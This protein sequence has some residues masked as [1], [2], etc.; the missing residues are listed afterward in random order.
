MVEQ[1]NKMF[2]VQDPFDERWLVVLHTKTIG[3]NVED[4][5]STIDTCLSPFFAQMLHN[6]NGEEVDDVRTNCNDHDEE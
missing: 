4:D 5:D 3:I 1:A 2:Y 6:V